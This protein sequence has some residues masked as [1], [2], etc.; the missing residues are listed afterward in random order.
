MGLTSL[1]PIWTMSL[2]IL[3]FFLE[4]TPKHA[5]F[6]NSKHGFISACYSDTGII[7][8]QLTKV[9]VI[10]VVHDVTHGT[11]LHNWLLNQPV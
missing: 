11:I 10:K 9:P 2:N 1:P 5:D 3:G 4:I 8:I 7:S 6:E